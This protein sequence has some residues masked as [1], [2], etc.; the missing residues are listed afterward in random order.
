[1]R[2]SKKTI[3]NAQD[4]THL[5]PEHSTIIVGLSGG[6]DSVCLLDLM[7]R[8]QK[9]VPL[10]IIAAHLDHGWR[11]ESGNDA[12]WC[13]NLCKQYNIPY[14]SAHAKSLDYQPTYNGSKEEVGRKLRRYFFNEVAQQHNA[15]YI[16]LAHHQDDII[17]NFFIRLLRGSSLAG[18]SGMK[19]VDGLYVRPLL[20]YTKQDILNYLTTHNLKYLTDATNMSDAY[21]RNRIRKYMPPALDTI[22]DRW[23]QN[24]PAFMHHA[25]QIHEYMQKAAYDYLTHV[26]SPTNQ[27]SYNINLF[28]SAPKVLQDYIFME[29]ITRHTLSIHPSQ[30]VFKEIIR[31]LKSQKSNQHMINVHNR[32]MK[33]NGYFYFEML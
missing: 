21:L 33:K 31:F 18:I 5:F 13:Q 30:S 3:I 29:L 11:P 19:T 12:I 25:Q 24:I 2:N 28:L 14:I 26:Q 8:I 7:V 10:T 27:N 9:T 4:L 15:Q 1:M 20:N 23:Q 17:E 6:P 22:D 16:A 32:I